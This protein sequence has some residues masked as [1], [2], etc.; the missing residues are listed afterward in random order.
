MIGRVNDGQL[1]E[2]TVANQ[3]INYSDL[4]Y[5]NKRK[6]AEID[7]IVDKSFALEVKLKASQF[8][9]TK[10][11]KNSKEIGI[12]KYLMVSHKYVEIKNVV[13]PQTL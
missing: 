3:L 8:D 1:F 2:N 7:F 11:S 4:T 13:Y 9:F 10:L 6:K 5:Y 12:G